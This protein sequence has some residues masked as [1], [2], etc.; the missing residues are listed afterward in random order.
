MPVRDD[1]SK[2]AKLNQQITKDNITS[3]CAAHRQNVN[4]V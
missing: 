3:T 4:A 1:R 2:L